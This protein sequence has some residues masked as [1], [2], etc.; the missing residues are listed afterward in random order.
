MLSPFLPNRLFNEIDQ[1]P[2]TPINRE[3]LVKY[4]ENGFDK[5]SVQQSERTIKFLETVTERDHHFTN[6]TPQ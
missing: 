3:L 1:N 4:A 5:S 2:M 6:V